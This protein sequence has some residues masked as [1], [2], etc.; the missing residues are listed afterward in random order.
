MWISSG[1]HFEVQD[2][3]HKERIS[4]GPIP[5]NVRNILVYICAKFGACITKCTIGLLHCYTIEKMAELDNPDCTRE[6]AT[7]FRTVF[8]LMPSSSPLPSAQVYPPTF[9]LLLWP[10]TRRPGVKSALQW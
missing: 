7:C 6:E 9:I 2:S 10:C 3:G 5:E 1:G 8:S 4:S